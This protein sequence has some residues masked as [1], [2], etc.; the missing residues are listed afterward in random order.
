MQ[1]TPLRDFIVGLFVL[2]GFA[3]LGYLAISLGG[4]GYGGGGGL[5]LEARFSEIGGLA[6]RAPVTISGVRV[7]E[8]RRIELYEDL[9]ARVVLEIDAARKLPVDSAAEI[10]TAGLLGD[11]F[12][13]LE[14]GAEEEY[15]ADGDSIE[16]TVNALS[17]DKLVG[18]LVHGAGL[19][20]GE[21]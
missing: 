13:A 6:V 9:D 16:Y 7:G 8:V 17:M 14:P 2:A 12:I 20:E 5:R 11:Q 3:A 19:G 18:Q 21:N 4:A 15:L 1:S 10:R